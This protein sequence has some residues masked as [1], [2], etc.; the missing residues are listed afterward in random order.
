MI[1]ITF[2]KLFFIIWAVLMLGFIL[3]MW[4]RS[5]LHRAK[6]QSLVDL[7]VA[8]QDWLGRH[9]NFPTENCWMAFYDGFYIGRSEQ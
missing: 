2:W 1:I 5:A 3:G 9:K 4:V 6:Q 8:W 7:D